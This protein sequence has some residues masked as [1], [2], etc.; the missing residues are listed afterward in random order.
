MH[1][2]D[3]SFKAILILLIL[4]TL[5]NLAISIIIIIMQC[6]YSNN[7]INKYLSFEISTVYSHLFFQNF[8]KEWNSYNFKKQK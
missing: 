5:N 7:L 1:N 8:G 4:K 6:S 2:K 3:I